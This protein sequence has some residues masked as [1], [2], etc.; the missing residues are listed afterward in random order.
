MSAPTS[1]RALLRPSEPLTKLTEARTEPCFGA[2]AAAGNLE[3]MADSAFEASQSSDKTDKS[4]AG[5]GALVDA[6]M[7]LLNLAGCRIIDPARVG[8]WSDLDTPDIRAALRVV[9][10]DEMAVVYLDEAR[11]VPSRFKLR[12]CPDKPPGESLSAW[13]KRAGAQRGRR[14]ITVRTSEE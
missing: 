6:A 8:I 9:G 5:A 14:P 13:Q 3:I 10:M 12:S 2:S 11:D 7:L 1:W 4:Q